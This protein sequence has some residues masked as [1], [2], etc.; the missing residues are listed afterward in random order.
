LKGGGGEID[1][2]EEAIVRPEGVSSSVE[3]E[4]GYEEDEGGGFD[5]VGEVMEVPGLFGGGAESACWSFGRDGRR[6]VDEV[7]EFGKE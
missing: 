4:L 3:E 7:W 1:A 5:E 2:C 6:G